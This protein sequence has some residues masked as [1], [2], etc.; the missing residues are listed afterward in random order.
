MHFCNGPRAS[1]TATTASPTRLQPT[2]RLVSSRKMLGSLRPSFYSSQHRLRRPALHVHTCLRLRLHVSGA[3][4]I[5]KI[6]PQSTTLLSACNRTA[7][8]S[9]LSSRVRP[10][11]KRALPGRS[12]LSLSC[13]RTELSCSRHSAIT[14][15]LL[16]QGPGETALRAR[17]RCLETS[18]SHDRSRL[19]LSPYCL[20]VH[21]LHHPHTTELLALSVN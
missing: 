10:S 18:P 19:Q 1:A 5:N 14:Y 15:G 4:A 3:A 20:I 17:Q 2:S 13:N 11:L 9:Q 7:G 6:E 21:V 8:V 12:H 16:L